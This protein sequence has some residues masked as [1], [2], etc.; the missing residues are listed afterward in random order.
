M[1]DFQDIDQLLSYFPKPIKGLMRLFRQECIAAI[2]MASKQM[3]FVSREDF[4]AQKKL[5]QDATDEIAKL[6]EAIK[7]GRS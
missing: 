3:G 1:Q 5:L 6:R 4:M 2:R 7:Q